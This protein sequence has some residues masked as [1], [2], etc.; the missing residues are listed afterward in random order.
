MT[1]KFVEPVYNVNEDMGPAQVCVD[2]DK[3]IAE[4]FTVT[5][6]PQD[7]TA[8]EGNQSAQCICIYSAHFRILRNLEIVLRKL[9]SWPVS[10]Q[11][12]NCVTSCTFLKKIV[13]MC[14][15]KH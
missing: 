9:T 11:S 1:V 3:K 2:K 7:G 6:T 14:V 4:S 13:L 8:V 5:L 12:R 10:Y 15:N